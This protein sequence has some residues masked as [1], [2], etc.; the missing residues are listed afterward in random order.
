MTKNLY[1]SKN[2]SKDHLDDLL[3][4]FEAKKI[5]NFK[6]FKK[7]LY[8]SYTRTQGNAFWLEPK[9]DIKNKILALWQFIQVLPKTQ[10]PQ[11]K[12]FN[13]DA[14]ND[15]FTSPYSLVL[16]SQKDAPFIVDSLYMAFAELKQEILPI[17]SITGLCVLRDSKGQ[18]TDILNINHEAPAEDPLCEDPILLQIKKQE[19]TDLNEIK[20]YLVGVLNEVHIAYQDQ[21]LMRQKA[22]SIFEQLTLQQQRTPRIEIKDASDFLTWLLDEHFYFLGYREYSFD[23]TKENPSIDLLSGSGLGL[24]RDETRAVKSRNLK[25]LPEAAQHLAKSQYILVVTKTN[26]KSRIHRNICTDY[27]SIKKLNEQGKVIGE[28]RFIGLFRQRVYNSSVLQIPYLHKKA[29]ILLEKAKT[30]PIHYLGKS[31]LNILENFPR[32]DLFQISEDMLYEMVSAILTIHAQCAT[33]MI[34]RKDSYGRFYS[35]F[36]YMPTEKVTSDLSDHIGQILLAALYGDEVTLSV[37]LDHFSLARLHYIVRITPANRKQTV[38]DLTK[39]EQHII[40]A[41]KTWTEKLKELLDAQITPL[42]YEQQYKHYKKAFSLAYQE[43]FSPEQALKD[44][45]Y[46]EEIQQTKSIALSLALHKED[47]L[48][49][50]LFQL[51]QPTTLSEIIPILENMGLEAIEENAYQ[52]K[53]DKSIIWICHYQL[54]IRDPQNINFDLIEPLFKE[55]F[56]AVWYKQVENDS[57]NALVIKCTLSVHEIAVL[58]AYCAYL[59][60]IGVYSQTYLIKVLNDYFQISKQLLQLFIG[61]FDPNKSDQEIQNKKLKTSIKKNLAQVRNLE[62]DKILRSLL[63]LIEASVRTNYY[64]KD[65]KGN[66]KAYLAFKLQSNQIPNLPLPHPLYEIFVYAPQFEAIH[67]RATKVARGGIRWS[68]RREDFRTEV[69]GLMKAQQVKN[70]VI[71]PG[72]SKGGFVLKTASNYMDRTALQNEAIACYKNFMRGL[73]DLTDNLIDN[74][75]VQPKSTKIY[76]EDDPYLVVAADKGTASFSDYANAVSAEYQF[77]LGDAFASGGSQGYDHKKMAITA[78]GAWISVENHLKTLHINPSTDAFTVVGIGDMSGDVFGN[79]ML[80]SSKLKLVAAFNHLHIFIDPNPDCS[81]SFLERKRLF[82]LPRS[83]WT[84]YNP[85]LISTGGGVFERS[86]K[87]IAVS[88]EMKE[89]FDLTVDEIE[90]NQ[91]ISALLQAKVDLLFNGGIGTYVKASMERDNEVGDKA[92]D[93]LRVNANALRCK[94]VGEG[95]NLGFTQ[96][97]R[98]EY[99]QQ[100]GLIFTDFIDNSAGVDLSDHEVNIKILLSQAQHQ[101]TL[102]L[103]QR[104]TLLRAMTTEVKTLVLQ[105]NQNQTEALSYAASQAV[106]ETEIYMRCVN[107]FEKQGLFNRNVEYLPSEQILEERQKNGMGFTAPEIAIVMAYVKIDVKHALLKSTIPDTEYFQKF[108]QAE[109]PGVLN[110]EYF[111][112]M[113]NHPLHREIIST[114][115]TNQ[116]IHHAGILFVQRLREETNA[117]IAQIIRAYIVVIK[118]FELPKLYQAIRDLNFQVNEN[119]Q[120]VMRKLLIRFLRRATRWLIY[121]QLPEENI[122]AT[123]E[124]LAPIPAMAKKLTR[125]LS[126]MGLTRYNQLIERCTEEKVPLDVAT[127]LA[128]TYYGYLL[129]EINLLAQKTQISPIILAKLYFQVGTQL[130]LDWLREQL[131]NE[132]VHNQWESWAHSSLRDKLD[133]LQSSLVE[134]ART[135]IDHLDEWL[136][137]APTEYEAFINIIERLKRTNKT[138]YVMYSVVLNTL[139]QLAEQ[140]RE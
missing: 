7:F 79:G 127:T 12:L 39:L 14:I 71:V 23:P 65:D 76:D 24:L 21:Q 32:D 40:E 86:A 81:K 15:G 92:N 53:L 137:S 103:K 105:D 119:M 87:S 68:D 46:I 116:L 93:A 70:A 99:A 35:C 107:Q 16:F 108:I 90:P 78:K 83:N 135:H 109:F 63:A 95:G 104:N 74:H 140:L 11:I 67:L 25:S 55:L 102:A 136:N 60:L 51:D 80:L 33:R 1:F 29:Q 2:A 84:D 26:T 131:T 18:L 125:F 75:I 5:V 138:D 52:C 111:S 101:Q 41:S 123:L 54:R 69:L 96:L 106:S 19:N 94:A 126:P 17:L 10:T 132:A 66:R 139:S 121:K 89:L 22:Q 9:E 91:L 38:V 44:I 112:L 73:L 113:R 62:E 20:K 58:R 129:L 50:K 56:F 98:V 72:G 124:N 42:A 100:G 13:P 31:I 134:S 27:L 8:Y 110:K 118:I 77:W 97:A 57:L 114:Q 122:I 36:I 43:N 34:V 45:T 59:K 37:Q 130:N 6:I 85:Q 28:Y 30:T 47:R 61:R 133:N 64:Q 4:L 82:A 88:A 48:S 128:Q 49:F 120:R 117:S 115:L 3:A